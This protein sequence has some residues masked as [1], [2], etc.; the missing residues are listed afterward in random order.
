MTGAQFEI[1]I[2]RHSAHLP[3]PQGL[4]DGGCAAHQEQKSAQHMVEVED[5]RSGDITAV[6]LRRVSDALKLRPTGLGSGNGKARTIPSAPAA[7]MLVTGAVL[8]CAARSQ[9]H[10]LIRRLECQGQ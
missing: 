7:G 2:G 6:A 1:R 3:R 8:R 5:L 4:R 10:G 9:G